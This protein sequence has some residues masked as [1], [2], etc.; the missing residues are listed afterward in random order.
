MGTESY[1][2]F[3]RATRDP[4]TVQAMLEDYRAGLSVDRQD[5]EADRRSGHTVQCPTLFLWSAHDDME[6]LYGD[7][8]TIWQPWADHLQGA[9]IDSGHHVAEENPDALAAALIDF[10]SS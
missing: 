2:E 1:Q 7:P 8:L 4:D 6:D 5:E 3:R 9:S 10:L